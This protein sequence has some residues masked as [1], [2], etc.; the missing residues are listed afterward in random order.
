MNVAETA[1]ADWTETSETSG[2]I[3]GPWPLWDWEAIRLDVQ[4]NNGVAT[5]FL[6]EW[7]MTSDDTLPSSDTVTITASSLSSNLIAA[8]GSFLRITVTGGAALGYR[9]RVWPGD[10]EDD[11]SGGS[12]P[13]TGSSLVNSWLVTTA[14]RYTFPNETGVNFHWI[15]VDG[16]NGTDIAIDGGDNT[17]INILTDGLYEMVLWGQVFPSLQNASGMSEMVFSM[18]LNNPDADSLANSGFNL[19]TD[20]RII[21]P[22]GY[23]Q[24]WTVGGT[25]AMPPFKATA[26]NT[27][28]GFVTPHTGGTTVADGLTV[29]AQIQIAR[30]GNIA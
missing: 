25:L 11:F 21:I 8:K 17:I 20:N 26:G 2:T 10:F 5:T 19:T 28:S 9:A 12:T 4:E 18:F 14:D 3:H 23:P 6:L 24:N 13:V 16:S 1:L 27:I 29:D 7:L 22:T 15:T 30:I